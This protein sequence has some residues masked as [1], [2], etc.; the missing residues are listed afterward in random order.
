MKEY[1]SWQP[2][3]FHF[4][5]HFIGLESNINNKGCNTAVGLWDMPRLLPLT[6]LLMRRPQGNLI[7]K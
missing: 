3:S 5:L 2:M 6:T 1:K 7:K 4:I